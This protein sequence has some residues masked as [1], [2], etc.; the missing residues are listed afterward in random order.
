MCCK[1]TKDLDDADL[2]CTRTEEH[3]RIEGEIFLIRI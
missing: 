1:L 3:E 2:C